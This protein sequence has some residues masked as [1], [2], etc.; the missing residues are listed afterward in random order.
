MSLKTSALVCDKSEFRGVLVS[1]LSRVI[2]C[3]ILRSALRIVSSSTVEMLSFS[4]GQCQKLKKLQLL[5]ILIY[6]QVLLPILFLV[7]VLSIKVTR[8]SAQICSNY[9]KIGSVN[10][11][12]ISSNIN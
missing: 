7:E 3:M 9:A 11:Y 10:K 5:L 8:Y 12:R 1:I 6:I 2:S 4:V